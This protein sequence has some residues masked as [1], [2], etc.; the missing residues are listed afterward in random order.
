V[1][2]EGEPLPLPPD[3]ENQ[4]SALIA[5][6]KVIMGVV[7]QVEAEDKQKEIEAALTKLLDNS[8][9]SELELVMKELFTKVMDCNFRNLILLSV[10]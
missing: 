7:Q 6:K 1:K 8:Y 4:L 5:I 2:R 9:Q 10:A 3:T